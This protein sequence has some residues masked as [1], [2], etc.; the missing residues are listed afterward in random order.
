MLK[1][2]SERLQYLIDLKKINQTALVDAKLGTAAQVSKW[3]SGS[4]DTPRRKTLQKLSEY[5]NCDINWLADGKGEP[6]P[7]NLFDK[8]L[9]E[10]TGRYFQEWQTAGQTLTAEPERKSSKTRR[11]IAEIDQETF[12]EIQAWINDMEKTQTGFTIWFRVEFQNRFE[13][14]AEWKQKQLKKLA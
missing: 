4:I 13:G 6:F 8:D 11:L 12:G 1:T 9:V 2:F 14:F 10:K 3:I 7:P 5:F